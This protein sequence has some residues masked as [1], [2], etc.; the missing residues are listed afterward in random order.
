LI[1]GDIGGGHQDPLPRTLDPR[2]EL[3]TQTWWKTWKILEKLLT[4][5]G[6]TDPRSP[7]PVPI[8]HKPAAGSQNE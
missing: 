5:S 1:F 4:R 8:T 7:N 3:S 2:Q 6:G